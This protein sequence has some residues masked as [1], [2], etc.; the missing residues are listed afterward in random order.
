MLLSDHA[1]ISKEP[2]TVVP[3]CSLQPLP[4]SKWHTHRD[5]RVDLRLWWLPSRPQ[6]AEEFQLAAGNIVVGCGHEPRLLYDGIWCYH[7]Q[8]QVNYERAPTQARY[9]S[10]LI[11]APLTLLHPLRVL[12]FA[13]IA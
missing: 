8:W 2:L 7:V 12:C 9:T 6:L 10:A 11:F 3:V 5:Q 4:I 13:S 1:G